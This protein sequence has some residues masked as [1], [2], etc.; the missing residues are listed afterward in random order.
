MGDFDFEFGD[1]KVKEIEKKR[2]PLT[3]DEIEIMSYIEQFYWENGS[4]P[5]NEK[6]SQKLEIEEVK[7]RQAWLK[8]GFKQALINRGVTLVEKRKEGILTPTQIVLVNMLLNVGDKTSLREKLKLVN[9]SQPQYN[10]WLRDP[11]FQGYLRM[12]T[13]QMFEFA[14]HDAFKSLVQAVQDG[15]V[16]AMKLFFEMRGIYNPK[17][18]LDINVETVVLRVVEIITKHVKDPV[19]LEAIARDVEQL[20]VPK[21]RASL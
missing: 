12:R 5:T 19:V 11:V 20:E 3:E 8:E 10:A 18:T 1:T 21:T 7:V 9:I 14:D 4:I 17:V 13:E 16:P 6:L 15:D 2:P